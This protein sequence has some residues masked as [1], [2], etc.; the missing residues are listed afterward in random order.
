MLGGPE[1]YQ[2]Q[3]A[4][5]QPDATYQ[6]SPQYPYTPEPEGYASA[7]QQYPPAYPGYYP[8]PMAQSTNGMA[9]ASLVCSIVSY[10][11]APLIG[12][13]LGVIFGHI[14]LSQ[15]KTSEE[16]GHGFA[17]AGLVLGYI[18][19]ALVALLV[20]FIIVVFVIIGTSRFGSPS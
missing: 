5:G 12:A 14:A 3:S 20:V 17:V 13:L 11:F 6:Q 9:I 7:P 19:L 1:P 16:Q 10:V 2:G 15:L 18:H 8:G 4:A